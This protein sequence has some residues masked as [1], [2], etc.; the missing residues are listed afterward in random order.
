L[1]CVN[2]SGIIEII[3]KVNEIIK[4][5]G[6]VEKDVFDL[7]KGLVTVKGET[8]EEG[9]FMVLCVDGQLIRY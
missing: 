2:N 3:G 1:I 5:T 7:K 6:K 9:V 4:G 8:G